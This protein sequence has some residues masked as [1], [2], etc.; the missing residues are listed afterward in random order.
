MKYKPP[1]PLNRASA[2]ARLTAQRRAGLPVRKVGFGS[3]EN[4]KALLR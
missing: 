3:T 2:A 4:I 1:R